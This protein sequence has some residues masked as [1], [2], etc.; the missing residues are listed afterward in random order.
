[1]KAKTWKQFR[2]NYFNNNKYKNSYLNNKELYDYKCRELKREW[3]K[4]LLIIAKKD[5][6]PHWVVTDYIRQFGEKEM[7]R[8]FRGIYEKGISEFRIP[9]NCRQK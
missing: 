4:H 5:P 6:L 1:M 3:I 7:F 8:T 2:D 9:K